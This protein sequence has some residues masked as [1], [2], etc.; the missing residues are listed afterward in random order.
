MALADTGGSVT[1][2]PSMKGRHSSKG[3]EGI[4]RGVGEVVM[5]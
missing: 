2:N 3:S 5:S 4:S 1:S